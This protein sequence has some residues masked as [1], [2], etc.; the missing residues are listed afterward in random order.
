MSLMTLTFRRLARPL[1][2]STTFRHFIAF[3]LLLAVLLPNLVSAGS[4]PSRDADWDLRDESDG[5]RIY[6]IDHAGSSFQAFKAEAVFDVPMDQLMAVIVTPS[7]CMQWVH[8]C[9]EARQFADGTFQKRFAY[10]VNDMPWPVTDR[11]YV[12]RIETEG[13]K[14]TGVVA[15]HMSAVPDKKKDSEDRVRVEKSDTF[16]RFEPVSDEKTR[17]TWIQHTEPNGS[18]PGWLVNTLIVDIPMKS[19]KAL[20]KLAR[21][22]QYKGFE[23]VYDDN[24]LLI[25]VVRT[26]ASTGD[27]K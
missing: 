22:D 16:Y 23:M 24:G 1:F 5:I 27:E 3:P 6:T 4:L 20:E 17:I 9:V 25:N 12:L 13:H 19:M 26:D 7:S 2:S 18:I 14:D 11:D 21:T 15:I 8:N 10:S